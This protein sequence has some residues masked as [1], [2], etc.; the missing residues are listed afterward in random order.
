MGDLAPISRDNIISM[1]DEAHRSQKGDG[2]ESQI[3]LDRRDLACREVVERQFERWKALATRGRRLLLLRD[4]DL[5]N[6]IVSL[7]KQAQFQ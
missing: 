3:A 6:A 2:A 1:V 7:V 4:P 5:A